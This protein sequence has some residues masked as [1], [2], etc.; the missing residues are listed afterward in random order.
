[1]LRG[2]L[3][4]ALLL[5]GCPRAGGDY[6]SG[7]REPGIADRGETNGR[8]FDFISDKP[9][10]DDWQIRIRDD[11]MWV[12]YADGDEVEDLGTHALTAKE[13]RRVWDLIDNCDLGG[14]KKGKQNA[15]TGSYQLKLREP[16]D[17]SAEHDE[18]SVFVSRET[19]D[20]DVVALTEYLQ[21]LI[22]KYHPKY[23]RDKAAL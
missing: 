7:G 6:A 14:R 19:E 3:L 2:S 9:D 4:V 13:A 8:M 20:E 23:K 17:E 15:D 10:G 18:I 21:K 22:G 16:T 1:M 5:A 12:S 11:S